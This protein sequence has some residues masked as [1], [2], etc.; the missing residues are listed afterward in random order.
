MTTY[1][2]HSV[3]FPGC[4]QGSRPLKA[5]L[6]VRK[7]GKDRWAKQIKEL[8]TKDKL[9]SSAVQWSTA[10]P[11]HWSKCPFWSS[12]SRTQQE[13]LAA[14]GQTNW[15]ISKSDFNSHLHAHTHKQ[16]RQKN[17]PIHSSR[18]LVTPLNRHKL[19]LN[20]KTCSMKARTHAH[21]HTG[22]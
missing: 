21:A 15:L 20:I 3:C 13:L 9:L 22:N 19:S 10:C 16:V 17:T 12:R 18:R 2:T 5:N 8:A 6:S 4:V 7:W 1:C 11:F 14:W